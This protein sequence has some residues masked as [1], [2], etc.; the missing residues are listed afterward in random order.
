MKFKTGDI[1]DEGGRY[2]E[3]GIGFG[4]WKVSGRGR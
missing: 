3:D 1:E 2:G 4:E